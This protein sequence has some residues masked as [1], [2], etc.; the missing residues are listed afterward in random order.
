MPKAIKSVLNDSN[1]EDAQ[2]RSKR[3][4]LKQP[5]F[6]FQV[7]NLFLGVVGLL[8]ATRGGRTWNQ[9][10]A[11]TEERSRMA[12]KRTSSTCGAAKLTEGFANMQPN[13]VKRCFKS[14]IG[15]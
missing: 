8:E 6:L 15:C 10:L 3:T 14:Y 7:K 13:L 1:Q 4:A 9:F 11:V 2:N 12:V 5:I